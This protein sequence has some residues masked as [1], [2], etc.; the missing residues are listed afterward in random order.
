MDITFVDIDGNEIEPVKPVRVALTSEIVDQVRRGIQDIEKSENSEEPGTGD[1]ASNGMIADPIVVHVD[2][3]GNAEQMEL[4]VPED[5]EPARGRTEEELIGERKSAPGE[6]DSG[7]VADV[8]N[9]HTTDEETENTSKQNESEETSTSN[10]HVSSVETGTTEDDDA[11]IDNEFVSHSLGTDAAVS[12]NLDDSAKSGSTVEFVTDSFSVYAIVYTVDFHWEVNGKMY[13]FS[14]PGGG[15]VSFHKLVEVLGIVG[16]TNNEENQGNSDAEDAGFTDADIEDFLADVES[17][18]FSNPELVNVSK[19]EEKTTVGAIKDGLG[20]E[21]KYSAELTEEDIAEINGTEVQAGDWALISLKAFDTEENLTVTMKDGERF[22][23]K[24]TDAQKVEQIAALNI[25]V[26]NSYIICYEEN[27]KYYVLKTDGSKEEFTTTSGFDKLGNEYRWAFYYVFKEKDQ[28]HNMDKEYYFIRPVAD[29]TKT[30]SLNSSG[31]A[32]LQV[33]TNNIGVLPQDGGG[34]I[35]EGYSRDHEHDTHLLYDGTGFVGSDTA[36]S[37][38]NIYMQ[39]PLPT[40]DFTV[41]SDDLTMGTVSTTGTTIDYS[42]QLDDGTS[43]NGVYYLAESTNTTPEV[44]KKNQHEIKAIPVTKLGTDGNN[45]YVF[46]HWELNN[47]TLYEYD[48]NGN[49]VMQNGKPKPLGAAIAANSLTIPSNGS[50]LKAFFKIDP[51]YKP[52]DPD[53]KVGTEFPDM[54]TWLQQLKDRNIPLNED[55]CNKTAEVY[56]YENRIYRVDLT[57]QSS[58]TT[59][60]GTIDLGFIMDVSNSMLFPS[61]LV[62]ATGM[63]NT[64]FPI[65]SINNGSSPGN[66][67]NQWNVTVNINGQNRTFTFYKNKTYYLISDETGTATVYKIFWQSGSWRCSDASKSEADVIGSNSSFKNGTSDTTNSYRYQIYEDGKV[68]TQRLDDLKSSVSTTIGAMNDLLNVLNIAKA[69]VGNSNVQKPDVQIAWNT[70]ANEIRGSQHTFAS[71]K[72]F[73]VGSITYRNNGGTRTDLA[74]QD[75]TSFGWNGSSTKYAV[76]ITDGAPQK[77]GVAMGWSDLESYITDLKNGS[78]NTLGNSDDIKLI[79]VGLSMDNVAVGRQLLFDMADEI[80]GEKGFY[81]AKSGDELEDILLHILQQIMQDA[82]VTGKVTDI[83]NEAFYPVDK[84]TGKPLTPGNCIDLDGNLVPDSYTG[85]KGILQD[86]GRTIIWENQDF[87]WKGWK[88]TVYVK[89][90]EDLLGGNAV[91]TND[92]DHPAQI[93]AQGYKFREGQTPIP[94]ADTV[95]TNPHYNRFSTQSSPRVNVNELS[96][97]QNNTEWTV[98][99]GT[100]VDPKQQIKELYNNIQVEEVVTKAKDTDGDGLPDEA[101]YSSTDTDNNYYPLEPNSIS[102]QRESEAG[103]NGDRFTFYMKDLIKKLVKQSPTNTYDWWDY[104]K[105]EVDFD[106]FITAASTENGIILNYDVYGLDKD[107]ADNSTVTIKLTSEIVTGEQG[108]TNSPHPTEVI[109]DSVEKYTLTVLYTPDYSVTPVGQGGQSTADFQVGTYGTLYQGHAAGTETS[110]NTHVINV[111]AQPL[112][113]LKTDEEGNTL[114]GAVFELYR[115]TGNTGTGLSE[116]DKDLTGTYE[117][118]ATVTSGENGIARIATKN[119][120]LASTQKLLLPGETYYLVEKT[121][122]ATY[123]RDRTVRMVTI[124]IEDGKYTDLDGA[125]LT[126][127]VY[128]YNWDQGARILVDGTPVSVTVKELEGN[129][130]KTDGSY[131]SKTEA[132]SFHTTIINLKDEVTLNVEKT[133]E[134]DDNPP[135]SITFKL[136]RTAYIPHDWD[137]G[138]ITKTGSCNEDGEITYT[139]HN[140]GETRIVAISAEGHKPAEP[141]KEI[142]KEETCGSDGQGYYQMVTYCSVCGQELSRGEQQIIPALEHD[143]GDWEVT[144]PASYD[145]PG[146]ETRVCKRNPEH[147]ETREIPQLIRKTHITY[148]IHTYWYHE[149]TWA[150]SDLYFR[151]E[152]LVTDEEYEVG[153]QVNLTWTDSNSYGAVIYKD[154]S[155]STG[156]WFDTYYYFPGIQATNVSRSGNNYSVNNITVTD[157]MVIDICLGT[158]ADPGTYHYDG[159]H[160]SPRNIQISPATRNRAMALRMKSNTRSANNDVM[161]AAQLDAMLAIY[162]KKDEVNNRD[163]ITYYE[164]EGTYTVTKNAQGEWK[165]SKGGLPKF[166]ENGNEYTYYVVE[167]IPSTG[168]ETTYL[169]QSSGLHNGDTAVIHNKLLKGSLKITK[170]VQYNGRTALTDEE[171]ALVNGSYQFAVKKG[172]VEISGSPFTITVI[173]GISNSVLISDLDQGTDYTIEETGSGSLVLKDASGGTAVNSNIVTATV[174]A[175]KLTETDLLDSA[176]AAFT[177]NYTA[178]EVIIVKVDTGNTDTKLGGAKFDLYPEGAVND[179]GSIKEG[180]VP[181][182]SDLVSSS[183]VSDKGKVSLG[184]LTPGT[185]YLFETEAPAGYIMM[186]MPVKI[187]VNENNISLLQGTSQR[188]G[189]IENEKTELM[190]MNSAGVELPSTGGPGTRLFTILGSILVM[191]AGVLLVR[192]RRYI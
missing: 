38:I 80:N 97:L 176:K 111:Y 37:V 128:P 55:G 93:E 126:G 102:D 45:K 161:T 71:A 25:D 48:N 174:T 147:V 81:S 146:V 70:F 190:V 124:E 47:E 26:N 76:L 21:C 77:S 118:V 173:N 35:L 115:K 67:N 5:I 12:E 63:T 9:E 89:A 84:A 103:E 180:A 36:S 52:V 175:G 151:Q 95:S 138:V 4:V 116:Y 150:Y 136:Y 60:D 31:Q 140:C 86:D 187:T 177:N 39:D 179:D 120:G 192:R 170:N 132:V 18:T 127:K 87:T 143:W 142:L 61:K 106:K 144:T 15:F 160:Y 104:A 156:W 149:N 72:G 122:P 152:N 114:P 92:K 44:E 43:V 135:D 85:P 14:M 40:Y 56:D 23:V 69:D 58:L 157:G 109:G 137:D 33:G 57:A 139:C 117:L 167:T 6:E 62:E 186:D 42:Q 188:S 10:D 154:A 13:D 50:E 1:G 159:Y 162:V 153:S 133:W 94:L 131:I 164:V 191:F 178:Y 130:E 83:V 145:A 155:P 91:L 53:E 141:V 64:L 19:V 183:S 96:F 98:Y 30:L 27:G 54:S 49:V 34:F 24:V 129:E 82:T 112:D 107:H 90:K 189:T 185:Y 123:E 51:N 165:W 46:D 166:D 28:L 172:G 99:V 101:N 75:A 3:N 100:E 119:D 181:L 125:D 88:G 113:V 59:F 110:E 68:G 168:Y 158:N 73:N 78:D 11:A 2:D 121:A 65:R 105:D 66:N 182:K 20:L 148:R 171:K 108:L 74:L 8:D 7:N 163:N 29:K 17:V 184:S 41:K 169:G 32:L 16:D 79:T 22:V 134:N